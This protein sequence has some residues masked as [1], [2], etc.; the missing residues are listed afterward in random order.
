MTNLGISGIEGAELIATGGSALVY[1]ATNSDGHPIAV[2]V[3]RGMRSEEVRRRF[4]R[5]RTAA[6]RLSGHPNIIDIV[7]GGISD[8]GEPFLVMPLMSRGSLADELDDRGAFSIDEAIDDVVAAADA[9]DFAHREGVLHRDLKPG[10]LL[11]T[12]AGSI[13]V[14][15]FGIARVI[16]AGIT[17]AT[18]GATT[19]VYAAPELL[20]ANDASAQSD[21]YALGATLYALLNG[22]PAFAGETNVWGTIARV[23][24][25]RV[26]W[27]DELPA[28]IMRVIEQ[29]M[30]KSPADR[31]PTAYHFRDNLLA[32]RGAHPDWRPP[33]PAEMTV[34]T[35]PGPA[36]VPVIPATTVEFDRPAPAR[37]ATE[38][39]EAPH[40]DEA[41]APPRW[42]VFERPSAGL[43]L[44][45]VGVAILLIA[46]AAWFAVSR[47][48]GS[49]TDV[50]AASPTPPIDTSLPP[51]TPLP[52]PEDGEDVD[53]V[54]TTGP[55]E[56]G[57]VEPEAT[58]VPQP[59]PATALVSF[60]GLYFQAY[61]PEGW[62]VA[63]SD[64]DVGYGFRSEFVA[65]GMYLNID[66]T[67]SELRTGN[68]TVE[69]S[70]RQIAST[71]SSAGEVI[72]ETIDGLTLH[73]FRF[74]NN[75]G[76]DS[77]DIFF[78]VDGD[79]YA[80]VAGSN[81][82]P[83]VAY[84]VARQVALTVRSAA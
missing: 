33:K 62:S 60:S 40:R 44:A 5:E 9:I 68:A 20:E 16:D 14:T 19:P 57:P 75:R 49:D 8:G 27:I 7:G 54:P 18:I 12:D 28:P 39:D 22:A 59:T 72:T 45:G 37:T 64:V 51:I 78:E 11:R 52:E 31:P 43:Q 69:Q 58:A 76:V 61:F 23:R 13:A 6:E 79:G 82:Q 30:A 38:V 81:S 66:T 2:K 50:G 21:V 42:T 83:E 74:R 48:L 36:M 53:A 34:S 26:P 55:D 41:P 77:I 46:G 29:A 73:S 56:D 47:A 80:I 10:N 67:P 71:I 15:D 70:A 35:P 32:A 25:E 4:Y 17:S 1:A 65:D 84:E 63:R 24:D 3:L